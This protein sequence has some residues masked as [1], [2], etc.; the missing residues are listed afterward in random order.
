MNKNKTKKKNK[1]IGINDCEGKR[2]WEKEKK[3]KWKKKEWNK[4]GEKKGKKA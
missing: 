2:N 1:I 3:K 4:S